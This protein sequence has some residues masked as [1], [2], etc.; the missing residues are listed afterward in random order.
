MKNV[1][2][3][4][5]VV[6]YQI[7]YRLWFLPLCMLCFKTTRSSPVH[8]SHWPGNDLSG[9]WLNLEILLWRIQDWIH[10]CCTQ[11]WVLEFMNCFMGSPS[12]LH[13]CCDCLVFWNSYLG[14]SSSKFGLWL[15]SYHTFH[16]WPKA[17]FR[18]IKTG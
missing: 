4:V 9:V 2:I 18:I 15:L 12:D 10:A 3:F 7:R 17:E 11:E 1:D 5:S 14:P 8:D 16:V 13:L 6:T